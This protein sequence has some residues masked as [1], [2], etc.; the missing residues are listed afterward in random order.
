[1]K[2]SI[3]FSAEPSLIF[4]LL[5]LF[6]G[7]SPLEILSFF[8]AVILHELGHIICLF[9]FGH[10]PKAIHLSLAGAAIEAD[11][12]WIPYRKEILIFLSGPLGNLIGCAAAFFLIRMEFRQEFLFFFFCNAL[13]G[14]FNLLP[15]PGLDGER[16][17]FALLCLRIEMDSAERC[18]FAISHITLLFCSVGAIFLFFKEKNPSLLIFL[19][20]LTFHSKKEEYK[21]NENKK[22]HEKFS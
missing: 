22:S 21:A 6:W 2:K 14:I 1:M 13:L 12:K 17:L 11:C 4:P 18:L 20:W 10:R 9:F 5:L 3:R 19:L 7:N 16:A 8:L 15:L